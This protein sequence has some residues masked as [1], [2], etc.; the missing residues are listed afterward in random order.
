MHIC[1]GTRAAAH[2]LVADHFSPCARGEI[3]ETQHQQRLRAPHQINDDQIDR[4]RPRWNSAQQ[5]GVLPVQGAVGQEHVGVR[6]CSIWSI[7]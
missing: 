6:R 1:A 4:M 2:H 3:P 5:R 7:R